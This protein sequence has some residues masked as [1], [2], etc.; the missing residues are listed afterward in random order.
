MAFAY[1]S[2]PP[3]QQQGGPRAFRRR[4]PATPPVVP[5]R[6]R[7]AKP[8]GCGAALFTI[9]IPYIATSE[10]LR[11]LRSAKSLLAREQ[12]SRVAWVGATVR[13]ILDACDRGGGVR[14]SLDYMFVPCTPSGYAGTTRFGS[15]G[16][17]RVVALSSW[18]P[19]TLSFV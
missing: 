7:D 2:L 16:F 17:P 12:S 4:R 1:A 9:K 18:A 11:S 19:C 13:A 10:K 3:V 6:N 14:S 15:F 8:F 5:H